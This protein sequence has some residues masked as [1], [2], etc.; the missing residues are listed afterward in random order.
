[1]K[2][3][4]I[5]KKLMVTFGTVIFMFCLT[6]VIGL[7]G[8]NSVKRNYAT[9]YNGQH[10]I[11]VRVEQM[12]GQ[13]NQAVKNL[14]FAILT[15]DP[16]SAA[17]YVEL[18]DSL[19]SQMNDSLTW[20]QQ[21]LVTD[22][23]KALLADYSS[24][25]S[26][27]NQIYSQL[28]PLAQSASPSDKQKA[29]TILVNELT[30]ALVDN[31]EILDELL[32]STDIVAAD[33]YNESM[34]S[35]S[36]QS[37]LM[38]LISIGALVVTI[39]LSVNLIRQLVLPIKEIQAAASSIENGNLKISLAFE[40]KDE[41]GELAGHIRTM[42]ERL[43]YYVNA[44]TSTMALLASGD[45]NTPQ[46]DTFLG[47]FLP[48]QTSIRKLISTLDSTL[49]QIDQAAAQVA[50]GSDQVASG[51]QALSQGATEQASSVEE[52]AATIND[53]SA[54]VQSTSSHVEDA[55]SQVDNVNDEMSSCNN[56]MHEMTAAMT[57]ITQKS[58]EISKIIKTIEDIAFQTNIL[59]LNAAVEAARA[60]AAGKGF[61]VVADEVRN[62]ASKSQDA[63][64][65]TSVADEVRNLASKSQDASKNTSILIEGSTKAVEKGKALAD[66]TAESLSRVVSSAQEV[67]E[68]MNKIADTSASQAVSLSQVSQGVDQISSVIQTNSAT[69]EE[70]A[71]AS[72]ELS[73]QSQMLK[74]LL[75]QFRLT[76][77]AGM[78]AGINAVS[79]YS[80][81]VQ[82]APSVEDSYTAPSYEFAG[83]DKY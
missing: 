22:T 59:A 49:Y 32:D 48:V 31:Q 3:L 9:F 24:K 4:S 63:S 5:S 46:Y 72:E 10:Q 30:P 61:A 2:N 80:S 42:S 83:S 28:T 73:G 25:V 45:L 26:V 53:L 33:S 40:S 43:S 6:V 1:M 60:G 78:N 81:P 20:L 35:S 17:S 76:S 12:N 7:V 56:Q 57:E 71:A 64:K 14:A 11:N 62:L 69:A 47:D 23:N 13:M 38:L 44:I 70:S 19:V 18:A 58:A 66:S 8:L 51:A 82:S 79:E 16:A 36:T 27:S 37:L 21:N 68:I 29:E 75:S 15:E 50:S 52:L 55:R 77:S 74:D 67:G 65:N 39:L 34:A 54:Q 41:L